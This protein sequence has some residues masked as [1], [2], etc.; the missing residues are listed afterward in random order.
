MTK[1]PETHLNELASRSSMQL[2]RLKG[3]LKELFQLDKPELDFGLYKIMHAKSQQISQF[4][5]NDLLNEVEAAFGAESAGRVQQAELKVAEAIDQAKKFGAPDPEATQAVTEARAAYKRA[6]E[7][8]NTQAEIYDHLYR[9]F[10]RYYDNGDFLSKRYYAREN[11]SR[12]APYSVPYDGR[13]VYLHWANKDQYYIKSGEYLTNFSFDLTEA[14]RQHRAAQTQG[15]QTLDFDDSTTSS[16]PALKVH[17]HLAQAQEGEHGNIKAAADQKREFIPLLSN[18]VEFNDQGELVLN[19]EYKVLPEG[20]P[21]DPATEAALKTQYDF[22]NKGDVP[23]H[24]MADVFLRALQTL[25]K[26]DTRYLPLLA[27]PVPTDT[28]KKRPLLAKYIQ[29]YTARNT[30]DYFIHKDLGG[31]LKRELDFYIKNELMRLDDIE[32]ADAPRVEDYLGKIKALRRIAHQLIA[33]L[34][35]LEDFQKKLW[36]KKKFVTETQYCI[37][38]DRVP[39]SLY[40]AIA[41]ND[42]QREEWVKLF[43]IDEIVGDTA[44]VGYSVPLTVEF[45]EGNSSLTIDSAFFSDEFKMRLLNEIEDLDGQ[46]GGILIQSE[47]SQALELM[48]KKYK[49]SIKCIYIDPPYN[50]DASAIAYKNAYKDSSWLSLIDQGLVLAK[51][52]MKKT[53]SIAVAIDDQEVSV[54]RA[55]LQ[56]NFQKEIGIAVVRSNPQSRKT[57]GKFSPVHEYALFYSTSADGGPSSIGTSE[58]KMAR[59]PLE[60]SLGNY[61][62]M[63]FIRAGNNDLR[64]DRP[65]LFYPIV[66]NT[67]N[68]IRIPAMTWIDGTQEYKVTEN[69]AVDEILV[70]PVKKV[71]GALVEKNWQRGHVRVAQE[72]EEYRVRRVAEGISIDFKTRMDAEAAPV[73]WWD[74][75]EYASA[76]YGA[77]ELK[78]LFLNCDFDYPKSLVLVQDCL[79]AIGADSKSTTLD[80]FGGSATTAHAVIKLNIDDCG[81]RKYILVEQNAYFD[82]VIRPRINKVIYSDDWKEGKP[83]NRE[84]ISHCF[85]YLRLESYE[86]TLNNLCLRSDPARER[87]LAD[88]PALRQDYVLNYWLDVETQG[89]QSLLNVAAFRDPTAYTMRIKQPGSDVQRLQR[90]DLIETFNW[91]IGLWVEHMAAPQTLEAEFTREVDPVLPKDQNTRL[92]CKRIKPAESGPYWFRLVEGYTLKVPGDDSSRQKTLVVWRKLTDDAEKD[93]AV[94]QHFLMEKLAISPREQTYALI[95]VN[96]SH[97]LPNPVVEGEQTKVRLIEEAFHNA[98]WSQE[99]V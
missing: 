23:A 66:V 11:D 63:N 1:N 79:K 3:L 27:E 31:F 97:T 24:W 45:L 93:N 14:V 8:G 30:M 53:A 51:K 49:E 32:N 62:W 57:R 16:Q 58:N 61:A 36:L 59:Y 21:I 68:K 67:A 54:L 85:K 96:G 10:E 70:Y 13:E 47:N 6:L 18:P 87:A 41:A 91:L 28:Q 25:D 38:L 65:K 74:K 80:Y 15:G 29:Q 42:A 50:T 81:N 60:D 89:S 69:I 12:A 26:D 64:S 56:N 46:C 72:Y 40:P 19:F 5:E 33:F 52:I 22:K 88:N 34:A 7:G 83:V 84:G 9:F 92:V 90:I 78:S 75:S 37:T 39:E 82:T 55:I 44:Q 17:M 2:D 71:N 77:A 76:N 35:Q 99:G 43:A 4:L 86:D 94:L 48:Q 73:T 20:Y 98:M 95:Y